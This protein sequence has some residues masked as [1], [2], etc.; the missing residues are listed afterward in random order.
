M[1]KKPQRVDWVDR[2]KGLTI[3]LVVL[4]HSTSGV[5]K[6]YATQGWMHDVIAFAQ[7][8][9]MPVFFAIAGLFAAKALKQEWRSFWDKK[10]FH[11]F[12]FYFLWLGIN[13][14]FK[15]VNFAQTLGL[16]GA[17]SLFFQSFVH[18]FGLL[19][20]IYMLPIFFLVL[21][22]THLLPVLGQIVLAIGLKMGL[23]DTPIFIV[24]KF[25][26]YYIFFI[27]GY[28]GRDFWFRLAQSATE[29]RTSVYAGLVI[30]ALVNAT[31]VYLGFQV[32][33]PM[34]LILGLTGMLAVVSF[35]AIL[36]N[37]GFGALLA[38]C[39]KNSLPI[40][41]G[42]FLPM[43]TTRILFPKLCEYCNSDVASITVFI[44][45]SLGAVAMYETV[46]RT[47]IGLFLYKRPSWAHL[48]PSHKAMT[49]P[50]E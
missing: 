43:V 30:W 37:R 16:D 40:Y 8:F 27:L 3:L 29:Q 33:M 11:F 2:A 46:K 39:G 44:V 19:W 15:G 32:N 9:R 20:F 38:Y 50:A 23:T 49:I 42:F 10:F 17:V 34:A 5:E 48:K 18:P 26:D 45:A 13:F 35:C 25:A 14:L 21:R 31:M 28:F 47:K 6:Y 12:Y 1:A 7:P 36:P 4:L 22:L 24:N 41:L